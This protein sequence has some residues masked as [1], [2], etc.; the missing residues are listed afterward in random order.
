MVTGVTTRRQLPHC[1]PWEKLNAA[2]DLPSWAHMVESHCKLAP[3]MPRTLS[4]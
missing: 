4:S 2:K 3:T 1:T